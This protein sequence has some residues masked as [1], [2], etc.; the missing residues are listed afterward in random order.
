M[1]LKGKTGSK[2]DRAWDTGEGGVKDD[3]KD[4]CLGNQVEDS[5][6]YPR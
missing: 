3:R 1:A 5:A 2:I 6:I 4:H